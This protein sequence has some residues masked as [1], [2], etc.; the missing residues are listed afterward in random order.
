MSGGRYSRLFVYGSL[1][2]G[3]ENHSVLAPFLSG[4]A[5]PGRVRGRLID[6]G[7][8]PALCLGGAEAAD[9]RER[10]VRGLWVEVSPAVWPTLDAFEGFVGAEEPNDYDRVWVRDA[11]DDDVSGWAY[12]WE[13]DRGCPVAASDWWPDAIRGRRGQGNV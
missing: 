8:Y 2:P 6:A 10:R 11:D 3:M 1:L 4:E 5:R 13:S 9:G 7:P 12:V